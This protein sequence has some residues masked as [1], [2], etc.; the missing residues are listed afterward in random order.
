MRHVRS[1]KNQH[2][3]G[4]RTP[5]ALADGTPSASAA[6]AAAMQQHRLLARPRLLLRSSTVRSADRPTIAAAAS[7]RES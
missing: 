4:C 2:G 7:E 1:G 6:E 5:S 3:R